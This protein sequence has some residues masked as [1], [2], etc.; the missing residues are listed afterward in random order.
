MLVMDGIATLFVDFLGS[1]SYEWGTPLSRVISRRGGT[2]VTKKRTRSNGEGSLYQRKSDN[3]WVGAVTLEGHKRKT[4]AAKTR[5]EALEKLRDLQY[6]R[7][8]GVLLTGRALTFNQLA[9]AWLDDLRPRVSGNTIK[10]YTWCLTLLR[11][12]LGTMRVDHIQPAHLLALHRSWRADGRSD[13]A[14]NRAYKR[15]SQILQ[16]GVRWNYL[17]V[18]PAG[19]VKTPTYERSSRRAM[20]AEQV[21]RLLAV[22]SPF[23]P[24]WAV[25][26]GVGLR[27]GE[28]TALTWDDVDWEVGAI[29][30]DSAI[31]INTDGVPEDG[32]PKTRTS[33]RTVAVPRSLLEI[34][35]AHR[36]QQRRRGVLSIRGLLFP[37]VKGGY[38]AGC[39]IRRRLVVDCAA[40]GIEYFS[41][42]ELR[43]TFAT[44]LHERGVGVKVVQVA[45]GHAHYDITADLYTH[46]GEDIR[47]DAAGVLADLF[48]R[49]DA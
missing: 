14:M 39:V 8:Q 35:A 42:H 26:V 34:L 38:L 3:L 23:R 16:Q 21:G 40:A 17:S 28:A 44:L 29:R 5:R 47:H 49:R 15:L 33:L 20:T 27:I 6:K 18:N 37:A 22:D 30:V 32:T 36:E 9:D 4:V 19:R 25:L 41:P 10:H 11:P 24:L 12:K 13:A 45:M 2:M 48:A 46:V 1:T 43:H 7:T 31:R